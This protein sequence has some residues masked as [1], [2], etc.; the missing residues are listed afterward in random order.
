[1]GHFA[2][3]PG[4]EY[5]S[6]ALLDCTLSA[7]SAQSGRL[8]RF[9][10][11]SLMSTRVDSEVDAGYHSM[12]FSAQGGSASGGD[13]S[14]LASGVYFFRFKAGDFVQTRKLCLI[15]RPLVINP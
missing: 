7:S 15:K 12:Q 10:I 2:F 6:V 14:G 4:Q 5:L 11:A 9:R 8:N 13:A 3:L 1:M